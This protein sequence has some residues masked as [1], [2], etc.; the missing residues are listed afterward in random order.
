[1]STK[2]FKMQDLVHDFMTAF[3]LEKVAH[4][5]KYIVLN[6]TNGEKQ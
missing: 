3:S 6:K 5:V 2:F 4:R 1:M